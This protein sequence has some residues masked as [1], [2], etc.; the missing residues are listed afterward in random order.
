[1]ASV[2][3]VGIYSIR[4]IG[5]GRRYIGSSFAVAK[6]WYQ[7]RVLLNKGKHHSS[8][9][10]NA[11]TK[12]GAARFEFSVLEECSREDL[13]S[14]EQHYLDQLR[15]VF[16]VC[17]IARSR[18]GSKQREEVRE[19]IAALTKARQNAKT[20]CPHGHEY[21]PDNTYI[22][23][24]GERRCKQCNANRALK[25]HAGLSSDQKSELTIA[26]K[27]RRYARGGAERWSAEHCEKLG[28]WQKGR[29]PT[30]AIE[31]SA[32]SRAAKTHCRKGHEYAV[33]GVRVYNGC[34]A[35]KACSIEAKRRYRAERVNGNDTASAAD[36]SGAASP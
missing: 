14:R 8:F 33:V 2:H 36:L 26:A 1:M 18:L 17:P 10:Q 16:N 6:R 5:T 21:T 30:V 13:L 3:K 35:C 7:H 32:A 23:P 34:R 15:P 22:S 11:W 29:V 20:Q 25:R 28:A 24:R 19:R 31:A 4:Q 12:H 9:L 27:R